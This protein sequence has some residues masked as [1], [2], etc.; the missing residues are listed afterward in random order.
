MNK[1]F[2]LE[3]EKLMND[4]VKLFINKINKI[5]IYC[6]S[7]DLIKNIKVKHY[8]KV[9]LLHTIS[10]IIIDNNNTIFIDVFNKK[11]LSSVKKSIRD[12]KLELNQS[13]INN[14]I[15]I[16]N[17]ILTNERRHNILK[18]INNETEIARISIR[19]IRHN[20]L[21]KIK[22]SYKKNKFFNKD[23]FKLVSNKIQEITNFWINKI[24][25]HYST[26]EKEI[27]IKN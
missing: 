23:E 20:Y 13:F 16:S 22:S 15:C 27:L 18:L 17:P 6:I 21:N 19:N 10:S 26:I 11:L 2:L 25:N 24:N 9:M 4:S 7:P 8:N 3:V 12:S 5:N 1:K 14:K